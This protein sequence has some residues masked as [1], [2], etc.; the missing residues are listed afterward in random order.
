[1][2]VGADVDFDEGDDTGAGD[3]DRVHGI[4]K[5]KKMIDKF[6]LFKD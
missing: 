4:V 1:M 6:Q 2:A 3:N 5:V